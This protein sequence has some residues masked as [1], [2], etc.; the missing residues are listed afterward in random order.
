[1][2]LVVGG[3]L[4]TEENEDDKEAVSEIIQ[5]FLEEFRELTTDDL[6]NDL[7]HLRNIQHHIDLVSGASLLNL[8]HYGMSRKKNNFFR[9]N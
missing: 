3:A 6:P 1:M 2:H 5:P 8:P 4:V 9:K 7:P